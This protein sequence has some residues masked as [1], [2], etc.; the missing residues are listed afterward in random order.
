MILIASTKPQVR[1]QSRQALKGV[2]SIHEARTL[3]TI[4]QSVRKL[5]P[6]VLLLDGDLRNPGG[7]EGVRLVHRLC[8]STK[9]IFITTNPS[10]NEAISVLK[11][12]AAG[13]CIRDIDPTLLR[14]AVETVQKGEV[15]VA[16]HLVRRLVDE[17]ISQPKVAK[18]GD[19]FHGLT[20]R[21]R[22]VVQSINVGGKNK[23]IGNRLNIT[24]KTVKRHLTSIFRKLNLS[25]RLELALFVS[26]K[27]G[28]SS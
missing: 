14:K 24:E 8:P 17:V 20:P 28:P 21:E 12:G 3:A 7:I 15:W 6:S 19:Q 9:I 4:E 10:E 2:A 16:R 5:K 18:L 25:D 11:A 27:S 23:D 26:R 22:E 13:Y 1:K